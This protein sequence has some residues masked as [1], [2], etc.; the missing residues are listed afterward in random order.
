MKEFLAIDDES[1]SIPLYEDEDENI[2]NE[3]QNGGNPLS[4]WESE[5]ESSVLD[6]QTNSQNDSQSTPEPK[7]KKIKK[8]KKKYSLKGLGT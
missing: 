4:D 6:D 1:N 8:K 3:S 5:D 2:E 7:A